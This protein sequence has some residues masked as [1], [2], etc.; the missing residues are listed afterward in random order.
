MK[1]ILVGSCPCCGHHAAIE[2]SPIF[3]HRIGVPFECGAC[4]T[5]L[6]VSP[7]RPML[8]R[9]ALMASYLIAYTVY[10]M[11]GQ[12]FAAVGFGLFG[13]LVAC[14]L[15]QRTF[16]R[17]TLTVHLPERDFIK[18]ELDDDGTAHLK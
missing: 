10:W 18:E 17:P 1:K 16:G 4:G 6:Q 2:L 15:I 3:E 13:F 8:S 9:G 12:S 14:L 5:L 11:N 7:A